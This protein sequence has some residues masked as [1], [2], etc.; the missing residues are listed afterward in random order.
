MCNSS[1]NPVIHNEKFGLGAH[2]SKTYYHWMHVLVMK[3]LKCLQVAM[4]Y[5]LH[6]VA[7]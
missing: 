2:Q 6:A 5:S 4:A 1:G 3:Q 7:P